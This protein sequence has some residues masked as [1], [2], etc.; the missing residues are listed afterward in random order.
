[1]K[2]PLPKKCPI[3]NESL[4]TNAPIFIEQ[5]EIETMEMDKPVWICSLKCS[6]EDC[7]GLVVCAFQYW[8]KWIK[9]GHT[10]SADP[11]VEERYVY[12]TIFES[13]LLWAFPSASFSFENKKLI[14]STVAELFVDAYDCLRTGKL[15]G[16]A[17]YARSCL[18]A[19]YKWKGFA[20]DDDGTKD[21]CAAFPSLKTHITYLKTLKWIGRD[22]LHLNEHSWTSEEIEKCLQ[23]L[24]MTIDRL[25]EAPRL[26]R[27]MTKISTQAF[28]N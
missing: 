13:K 5:G 27:E 16:A 1:M 4:I 19:I 28:S 3:C 10:S 17:A 25:I 2:L 15:L 8:R 20:D 21:F 7:G 14:D 26:E 11:R 9:N 23:N 6:Q 22:F 12:D 18:S 24:L